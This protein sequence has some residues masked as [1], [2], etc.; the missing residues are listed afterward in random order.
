MAVSHFLIRG[1]HRVG[2]IPSLNKPVRISEDKAEAI[3]FWANKTRRSKQHRAFKNCQSLNE[4]FLFSERMFGPHQ[5]KQEILSFLEFAK[6][7]QPRFVCEIGT[8]DGGTNFLLSQALPSVSS[9][10]GIDLYVKRKPQLR[11]FSKA[12]QRFY[13]I[14][15]ASCAPRTIEKVKHAL[16]NKKLD[17]LFIDGDHSYAGVRQDFLQYRHS[18]REGGLIVFHDIIPDYF[19]RYG[20]KTNRWVGG[21]PLFWSEIKSLYPSYEFV[22]DSEQDGLGIGA[23]RYSA[24]VSIPND[25]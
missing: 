3:L 15:G 12:S 9:M 7:E 10:L 8:A 21:V 24:Q 18:V 13:F 2:R 4:Y 17:L 6:T 19:S 16:G 11:Y 20:I 1:W 14:D 5:I 22:E 23:I 25:L